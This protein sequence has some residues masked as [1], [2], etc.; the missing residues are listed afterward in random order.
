[1]AP[2]T[3]SY[4]RKC[5]YVFI[6]NDS[7]NLHRD[8]GGIICDN[9][10]SSNNVATDTTNN[11]K[12]LITKI[13]KLSSEMEK[14]INLECERS[15]NKIGL[16]F[17]NKYLVVATELFHECFMHCLIMKPSLRISQRKK[18]VKNA[19]DIAFGKQKKLLKTIKVV[20]DRIEYIFEVA[21][22]SNTKD[23]EDDED[24]GSSKNTES[25]ANVDIFASVPNFDLFND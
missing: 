11:R 14:F 5:M 9:C 17:A 2:S 3:V 4:F 10:C 15:K 22:E 23:S 7:M 18:K 8:N 25:V 6:L 20:V 19:K 1:M 21:K 12:A 13:N 16:V 24:D